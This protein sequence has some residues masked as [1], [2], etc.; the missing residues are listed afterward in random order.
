MVERKTIPLITV[1]ASLRMRR[2]FTHLHLNLFYSFFYDSISD[3]FEMETKECV[4]IEEE[5][6]KKKKKEIGGMNVFAS[7]PISNSILL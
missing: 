2:L 7:S 1:P 4:A 5:E 3:A 6:K